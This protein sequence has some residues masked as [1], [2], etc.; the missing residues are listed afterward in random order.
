MEWDGNYC[1][2]PSWWPHR[3]VNLPSD[4]VKKVVKEKKGKVA[5]LKSSK[6]QTKE[7]KRKEKKGKSKSKKRRRDSSSRSER[8]GT[9]EGSAKNTGQGSDLE[10]TENKVPNAPNQNATESWKTLHGLDEGDLREIERF[11][12]DVQGRILDD[13]GDDEIGPK[14]LIEQVG[15]VKELSQ[16]ANYGWGLM[17]GEGAAIAQFVQNNMRIPRRGEVG[18]TGTDI[19]GLESAGYV[20]SGSR[21]TKMNAT[22]IRKENQVYSAEEK[23]ALKLINFEEQKQRENKILGDFRQILTQRAKDVEKEKE[24]V[25]TA[26]PS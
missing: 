15:R 21:H 7:K 17:P 12:A 1:V 5:K 25:E 20:M 11:K 18:W 2:L 19:E 6:K 22:R 24:W 13:S 3:R 8:D 10:K 16:A 9:S 23:R 4:D 14:P 26:A